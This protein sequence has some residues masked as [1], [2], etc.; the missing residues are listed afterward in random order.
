VRYPNEQ[1]EKQVEKYKE[2][3]AKGSCAVKFT[4]IT[5][6][7]HTGEK[8]S[9]DFHKATPNEPVSDGIMLVV[10]NERGILRVGSG[11]KQFTSFLTQVLLEEIELSE[12]EIKDELESL[13][14]LLSNV[15]NSH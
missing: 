11:S 6:N 7:P 8:N 1:R 13:F 3:M 14:E 15:S 4:V 12:Q 2:E 5:E 9:F 10:E